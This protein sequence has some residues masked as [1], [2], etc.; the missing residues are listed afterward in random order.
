MTIP[1]NATSSSASAQA[2]PAYVPVLKTR[3]PTI[4]ETAIIVFDATAKSRS[5]SSSSNTLAID[6][7]VTVQGQSAVNPKHSTQV[8]SCKG[9][10]QY[11]KEI[12][13]FLNLNLPSLPGQ[14]I[15]D[16]LRPKLN[17]SWFRE[18]FKVPAN[19][20]RLA[21]ESIFPDWNSKTPEQQLWMLNFFQRFQFKLE[22]FAIQQFRLSEAHKPWHEKHKYL[23]G[24][25]GKLVDE[26]FDFVKYLPHLWTLAANPENLPTKPLM[27][28][29]RTLAFVRRHS[30]PDKFFSLDPVI[31]LANAG[32]AYDITA[33][34]SQPKSVQLMA[35]TAQTLDDKSS[36]TALSCIKPPN[37]VD[38]ILES[39]HYIYEEDVTG[40]LMLNQRLR[41]EKSKSYDDLLL[42]CGNSSLAASDREVIA[43][44]KSLL[45]EMKLM[46]LKR[47]LKWI[48][49]FNNLDFPELKQL[50]EREGAGQECVYAMFPEL[51]KQSVD[52]QIWFLRVFM[53]YLK[54][55]L[56]LSDF[57]YYKQSA[58]DLTEVRI[59]CTTFRTHFKDL[60]MVGNNPNHTQISK[61]VL[62]I[63]KDL[64]FHSK[65]CADWDNLHRFY[66]SNDQQQF[67]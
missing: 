50:K 6:H 25:I 44:E 22:L 23:S 27:L 3:L 42:D 11:T 41:E 56:F 35:S 47:C 64:R 39:M 4:S 55:Q 14:A 65:T 2:R 60:M 66:L 18:I 19:Q 5:S 43:K 58:E 36:Q 40:R 7:T 15:T 10:E 31:N 8:T 13:F 57:T 37:A 53:L 33:L 67:I 45:A 16:I 26:Y 63:F 1:L 61:G 34:L 21:V 46:E 30:V 29:I 28:D 20:Q 17:A 51:D 24:T 62:E 49:A 59:R 54:D 32:K 12:E 48:K 9:L 52:Q 38:E